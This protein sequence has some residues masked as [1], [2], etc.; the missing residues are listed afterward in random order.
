MNQRLVIFTVMF[1]I[2]LGA[3][4]S[5]FAQSRY[6][7]LPEQSFMNASLT[8]A[9]FPRIEAR[10][11]EFS[12]TVYF[13][14]DQIEKASVLI[15]VKT[16]SV[17]TGKSVWDKIIRSSRL[18]DAKNYPDMVLRSDKIIQTKE[19]YI[20]IGSLDLHGARHQVKFPFYV[21]GPFDDRQGQYIKAFGQWEFNRKDYGVIWH[22]LLD[23]GGVVVGDIV[24]LDWELSARLDK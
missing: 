10:F 6:R 20:V 5:C 16:K 8:Y 17:D 13:H 21:E 3:C 24:T 12:G 18:L 11:K 14:P 1:F 22:D 23:K 4:S 7:I 9:M 19:G 2:V 15:K